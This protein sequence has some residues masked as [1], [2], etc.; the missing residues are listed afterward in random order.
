MSRSTEAPVHKLYRKV[1][2]RAPRRLLH[3]SRRERSARPLVSYLQAHL[4][5][6][7]VRNMSRRM[8][9]LQGKHRGQRCFIMGSGPSLNKMDLE[10]LSQDHVWGVNKCYL[11]FERISWRPAF[12]V[13]VDTRVV[14]DSAAEINRLIEDLPQTTCFFPVQYRDEQV[15]QSAP[16]VY[17]YRQVGWSEKKAPAERTFTTDAS[18]WVAGV[19]TVT[20]AAMQLAVYLG[21]NP[22]YLIGCDTS[23][24]VPST[25]RLE[26]D[27]VDKLIST[28]DD[29][30]SH[31]DR[32][33]FGKGSKWHQPHV[34]RMIFH[35]EKAKQVCD[36]LGLRVF[37]ATVGGKLEVFP[38]IDYSEL[39]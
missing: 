23:Y 30:R 9:S 14:P 1:V 38:R 24:S 27:D 3:L 18:R 15:L 13:A 17:W 35:Y 39:F 25:V 26:E 8:R 36:S 4:L 16:N 6:E 28:E 20:I 7:N 11:L 22:I 34:E 29:D 10:L 31:F 33:Y 32:R 12:Y 2:P 21:F 37:N 5:D 19:R